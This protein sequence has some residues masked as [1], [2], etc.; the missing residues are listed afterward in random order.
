MQKVALLTLYGFFNHGNK[1]QNYAVQRIF[2]TKGYKVET[3]VVHSSFI[4][5]TLKH[6]RA[7]VG[8]VFGYKKYKRYMNFYKFSK[9]NIPV[10]KL[11]YKDM[12][13]PTSISSEYDYFSVGSD[14]VWNPLLRHKERYNYFL[15]FVQKEQRIAISPSIAVDEIPKKYIEEFKDGLNGFEYITV[16]EKS[17]VKIVK[18][19]TG[20]ESQVLLDPTMLISKE[21]WLKFI[22]QKSTTPNKKYLL[23]IFLGDVSKERKEKLRKFAQSKSLDIVELTSSLDK[24]YEVGPKGFLEL[25][26]NAEIVCSDSFHAIAFSINFH[27]KFFAFGRETDDAVNSAT[28]S[29]LSTLLEKFNFTDCTEN[30]LYN[31]DCW[32]HLKTDDIILS[33]KEKLDNYLN[34][35][36]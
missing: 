9:E 21:E 27:K 20:K 25:I 12:K 15:K 18:E 34:K 22:P 33:E 1:L 30:N 23:L 19:L 24:Y 5:E 7:V 31:K 11:Y 29:R 13:L 28:F 14:Q 4:K 17:G 36:L 26:K 3:I 16:R 6:V 32:N 10:R 35:L 8:K 2:E